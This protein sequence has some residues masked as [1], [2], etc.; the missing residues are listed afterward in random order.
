MEL[1]YIIRAEF[2]GIYR[3]E[4]YVYFVTGLNPFLKDETKLTV[5]IKKNPVNVSLP[6]RFGSLKQWFLRCQLR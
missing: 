5:L 3:N 1:H 2:S 6:N 4:P